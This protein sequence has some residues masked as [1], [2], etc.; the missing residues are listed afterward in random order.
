MK[1]II[2]ILGCI[3]LGCYIFT[4]I[5]GDNATSIKGLQRQVMQTQIE[6]YANLP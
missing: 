4:L 6:S 2:I 1:K 5:L 3:L